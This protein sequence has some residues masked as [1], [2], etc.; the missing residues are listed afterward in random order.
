MVRATL[1]DVA[2][3]ARALLALRPGLRMLALA[4]MLKEAKYA[5][6]YVKKM[7]RMH[8]IWGNGSLTTAALRRPLAAERPVTDDEYRTLILLVL[9]NLAVAPDQT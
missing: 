3:V 8:P 4:R 2:L 9:A 5:T 7:R 1:G 6:M